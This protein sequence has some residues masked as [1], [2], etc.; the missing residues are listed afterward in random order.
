MNGFD[1]LDHTADWALRVQ[2][3]D[4]PRL[5]ENAAYGMLSL[6][7]LQL[8]E[9][10]SN[11]KEIEIVADDRE[12]LLVSFLEEL[13]FILE[14]EGVAPGEIGVRVIDPDDEH[15]KWKALAS[16]R[17]SPTLTVEKEIKAVTYH[18]LEIKFDASG[19]ETVLVFDV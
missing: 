7:G 14:S 2:A 6:M 4:L 16:L 18:G 13:L 9:K 10:G 15:S 5:L 3:E 12:E 8:K 1:E 11:L 17:F 19:L